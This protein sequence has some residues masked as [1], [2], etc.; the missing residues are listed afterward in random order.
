MSAALVVGKGS[1]ALVP[2]IG[3]IDLPLLL[4]ENAVCALL[5][6]MLVSV[7]VVDYLEYQW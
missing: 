6:L 2:V 4:N 5:L 7:L 3:Y 1:T